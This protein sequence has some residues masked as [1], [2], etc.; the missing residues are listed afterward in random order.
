MDYSTISPFKTINTSI[1]C[2]NL[3]AGYCEIINAPII[4]AFDRTTTSNAIASFDI[5]N[6]FSHSTSPNVH[7]YP[8][9]TKS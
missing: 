3:A 6:W 2:S 7:D 5:L 4:V 1:N 8:S 9:I